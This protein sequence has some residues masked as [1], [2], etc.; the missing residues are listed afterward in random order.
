M[1]IEAKGESLNGPARIGRVTFSKTLRTIYYKGQSFSPIQGFKANY[2][3]V[4]PGRSTRFPDHAATV[5]IVCTSAIFPL[6][7]T[8][9]SAKSIG[10]KS[11]KSQN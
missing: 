4:I 6:R 5:K 10:P 9:T 7:S 11:V 2:H 1:Y 8:M 3:A